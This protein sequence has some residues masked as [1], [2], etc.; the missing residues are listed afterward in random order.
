MN[1]VHLFTK[2]THHVLILGPI[3]LH[4]SRCIKNT[5]KVQSPFYR[6]ISAGAQLGSFE[7]GRAIYRGRRGAVATQKF[8]IGRTIKQCCIKETLHFNLNLA[9]KVSLDPPE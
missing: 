4:V 8:E 7:I 2:L 6:L 5:D 9:S 3:S 1:L